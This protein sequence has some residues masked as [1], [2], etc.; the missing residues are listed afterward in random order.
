[1]RS[2]NILFVT[3]SIVATSTSVHAMETTY[4]T[5][6][7][8]FIGSSAGVPSPGIYM[9]DQV[10]TYQANFTGP[11]VKNG[12]HTGDEFATNVT[13]F[14]FVPGWNLLGA[15]YDA[16]IAQSFT[17]VSLGSPINSQA[18]GAHNSYIVPV[19]LSWALG[20]S[21]LAVKTGLGIYIPD[22]TVTGSSG[23]G[24]IGMPYYTFQPEV[25]LSYL[26]D[27]WNLSSAI[28]EEFHTTNTVDQYR[29]GD[30][31]HA[32]FT[33]TKR[34]GKWTVGP[35]ASYA[36]QVSNDSSPIVGATAAK[37][38]RWSAW[39]VGALVGYDFGH[40]N[41]TV[42]ATQD[43]STKASNP[44]TLAATGVDPSTTPKGLMVLGS[45]SFRIW[46]PDEPNKTPLIH[47]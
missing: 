46:A 14:L 2:S 11:G 1:M 16:V 25:I 12:V 30:I 45:L 32:D 36:G 23:T 15:K 13:G 38:Q 22:G 31:L 39:A 29:T 37:A 8:V 28:Y 26:K 34:I 21:G 4:A 33:A 40:V 6:P 27:G 41:L 19:E 7:G 35:V 42:W 24:N 44:T 18:A 17:N 43:I 3:A 10:F 5:K 47:K 20:E 9:F